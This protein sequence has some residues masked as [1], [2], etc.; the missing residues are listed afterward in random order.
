MI[1]KTEFGK[2]EKYCLTAGDMRVEVITLGAAVTSVQ[3]KGREMTLGYA[4]PEEYESGADYMGAVIGRYAGRIGGAKF[5]LDGKEYTLKANEGGN[6]LH[7]GPKAFDKRV[8]TPEI[9]CA[10]KLRF[11]LGS[12]VG[13]NGFPG[14]L[15]MA[16][17]YTVT[18]NTLHIDFEGACAEPTVF[19]PSSH[20][21]FNLDGA[22]SV[23]GTRIWLNAGYYLPVNG[24][25]L[26]SEPAECEGDFD[27]RKPREL[28]N[29]FDHCFI[30][31]AEH[32]A[33]AVRGDLTMGMWTDFPA[34][35]FYTGAAL[36]A[37]H[38][39]NG[40]FCLEPAFLP[41]SPN[42][43]EFPSAVLN[44]GDIFHKYV[45]YRFFE[46]G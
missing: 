1:E 16:V 40:G 17:T 25:K 14:K 2:Y 20:I 18:E 3:Y 11:A 21:F 23:M 12:P 33:A 7:G 26:P 22:G 9:L 45:E 6:T 38:H 42:R 27:F 35:Q 39:A 46:K 24:E 5:T 13:D 41:D 37:P 36:S 31:E 10:N 28:T 19:A 34:V 30:G 32:M 43:P 4:S 8:W 15:A 29:D 44:P